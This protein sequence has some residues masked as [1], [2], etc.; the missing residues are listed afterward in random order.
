ADHWVQLTPSGSAP[1]AVER[2]AMACSDAADACYVFGGLVA[3]TGQDKTNGLYNYSRS[4]E[5]PTSTTTTTTTTAATPTSANTAT[6][7][8]AT[9]NTTSTMTTSTYVSSA[10]DPVIPFFL[11]LLAVRGP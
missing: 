4:G 8:A 10:R 3:S 9:T 11:C 6:T 1:P 5:A 2:H 7:A